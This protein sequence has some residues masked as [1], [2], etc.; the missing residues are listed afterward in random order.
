[1]NTEKDP[2]LPQPNYASSTAGFPRCRKVQYPDRKS[3]VSAINL[4]MK[5]GTRRRNKPK[6]LRT[7]VCPDCQSW[8]LTSQP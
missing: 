5:R 8:H 7:F 3:A 2:Y 4:L 6:F 1:M